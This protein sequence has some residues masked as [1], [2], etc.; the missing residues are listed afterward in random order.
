[1][2]RRASLS[3]LRSPAT[4]APRRA[5]ATRP[6]PLA[7]RVTPRG[8]IPA[9]KTPP[10]LK[11]KA[12]KFSPLTLVLLAT[13]TGSTTYALGK[14]EGRSGVD[15]EVGKQLKWREP[16][17]E[18]FNTALEEL[19]EYFPEDCVTEDRD[20]LESHGWNDWGEFLLPFSSLLPPD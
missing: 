16:T 9:G 1:M 2:L 3:A 6:H 15:E 12:Q 10:N 14:R 13:L 5:F 8:P 20:A 18:G 19:R 17:R 11:P 7:T 4:A